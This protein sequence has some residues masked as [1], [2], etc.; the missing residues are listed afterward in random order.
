MRKLLTAIAAAVIMTAHADTGPQEP[1]GFVRVVGAIL[2]AATGFKTLIE[3]WD[4]AMQRW[5]RPPLK[6]AQL[7]MCAGCSFSPPESS[8]TMADHI[9]GDAFIKQAFPGKYW[10]AGQGLIVCTGKTCFT[11]KFDGNSHFYAVDAAF[12]DPLVGYANP[13]GMMPPPAPLPR[14]SH[15]GGGETGA[16]YAPRSST[17]WH[18]NVVYNPGSRPFPT[19]TVT[20]IPGPGVTFGGGGGGGSHFIG[21]LVGD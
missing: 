15:G 5:I 7:W 1:V 9:Q 21:P 20:V 2:T 13:G 18:P 17:V 16:P 3:A 19:G 12:A 10:Q 8:P 14:P 6:P 4:W 11:F